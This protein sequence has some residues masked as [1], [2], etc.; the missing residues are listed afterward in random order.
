MLQLD[1]VDV[2]NNVVKQSTLVH[3]EPQEVTMSQ[4][5][6]AMQGKLIRLNNVQFVEGDTGRTY[7]TTI[8][9]A[10]SIP[11]QKIATTIRCSCATAAIPTSPV[12]LF[13]M[14]GKLHGRGGPV[15]QPHATL[16]PEH[17]RSAVEW[18]TLRPERVLADSRVG[19]EHSRTEQSEHYAG[20]LDQRIHG[21]YPSLE[22][23]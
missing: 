17:Q 13:R 8:M 15:T 10:T 4:I 12:F 21:R 5:T 9:Q 7:A 16:H 2:D 14:A 23:T 11:Y 1:S 20:M 22:S 19:L 18:S 3:V 6:P